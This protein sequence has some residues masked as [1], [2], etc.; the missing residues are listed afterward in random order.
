MRLV[1][2]SSAAAC[3]RGKVLDDLAGL[4]VVNTV[5]GQPKWRIIFLFFCNTLQY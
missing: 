3:H 1:K 4:M 5:L 2:Y